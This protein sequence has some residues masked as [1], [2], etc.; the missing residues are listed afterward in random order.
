MDSHPEFVYHNMEYGSA[1]T[2]MLLLARASQIDDMKA[3]SLEEY[4]VAGQV[5][6]RRVSSKL[7]PM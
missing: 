6:I 5:A 4:S 7:F 3:P 2:P 1:S